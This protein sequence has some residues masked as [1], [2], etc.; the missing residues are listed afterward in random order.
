MKYLFT[1]FFFLI[2]IYGLNEFDNG[3]DLAVDESDY[4]QPYSG[5][6]MYWQYK[7]EPIMLIGGSDTDNAFQLLHIE[8]H[9]D[10]LVENGGN[11]IRNTMAYSKVEDVWPY[12]KNEDGLFDLDR[13]NPEFFN[14]LEHFVQLSYERDIIVQMEIWATWNYYAGDSQHY[15]KRG[16]DINPFNPV[17]NINYTSEES[18]LPE[19]VDWLKQLYPGE[20]P[21]FYTRPEEMN[22]ESALHFQQAFIDKILEITFRYPNVLYCMNNETNEAHSWGQYWAQYIRDAAEEI[23]IPV[24]TAD[25]YDINSLTHPRHRKILNDPAFTFVDISQNNFHTGEVHYEMVRYLYEYSKSGPHKPVT[26]TKIYGGEW[27]YDPVGVDEAVNRFLRNLFA[28]ASSM[29][30]HRRTANPYD[31]QW[32]LYGLGL[33]SDAQTV[34]RSANMLLDEIEPWN[35]KPTYE[36]LMARNRNEA[37]TLAAAGETYAVFFTDGGYVELDLRNYSGEY[38]VLWLDFMQSEWKDPYTVQ[39]GSLVQ[40]VTPNSGQWIAVILKL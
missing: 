18:G 26:N 21:F 5:N 20:H 30:F 8:E 7:G 39:A 11:Y 3:I 22:L 13:P 10:L 12:L 31:E 38:R 25:M 29:R 2:N 16:W 36:H 4:I 37:Y 33:G 19:E 24:Q 6:P 28:G 15:P 27:A 32:N 14:R 9:L 35:L 23:G 34:I 1:L 17:N 40:L